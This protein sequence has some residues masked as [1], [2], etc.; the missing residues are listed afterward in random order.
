METKE[1]GIEDQLKKID[2]GTLSKSKRPV[3]SSPGK[4]DDEGEIDLLALFKEV[5]SNRKIIYVTTLAFFILGTFVAIMTPKE[6]E[7]SI[8]LMPQS[9]SGRA[10]TSN[11]L[12]QFGGLAGIDFGSASTATIGVSLYPDITKSTPFLL[13]IINQEVHVSGLD[14][15]VTVYNYFNNIKEKPTL[16]YIKPYTIG[17]PKLII[18]FPGRMYESFTSKPKKLPVVVDSAAAVRDDTVSDVLVLT[19]GQL[20]VMN[21]VRNRVETIIEP[22]GTVKI[23]A[24]MPDPQMAAE[25]TENT[26]DF[27]TKYVIDYTTEKSQRNLEFL[28][29]QYD[30]AKQ[31]YFATQ[32]SLARFR[33]RNSNI[34]TASAQTELE[35]LQNE[36]NLAYGVYQGLAQQLEQARITVQEETPVF[37]VLEPIQVPLTKSEPKIESIILAFI[38]MG[39]IGSLGFLAVRVIYSNLK[40]KL[41]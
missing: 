27:L 20:A 3:F 16:D 11:I 19:G 14:T 15:T 32:K 24:K 17:L 34:V 13:H 7:S 25:V 6:Y 39:I 38:A 8:V 37:K 30:K 4:K 23:K 18:T 31:K 40:E 10:N 21:E 36:N 5:W 35:R 26:V 9:N 29:K 1:K 2:K 41:N 22:N 28:E 12:K 33:D